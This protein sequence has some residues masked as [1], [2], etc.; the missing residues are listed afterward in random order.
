MR[1][2]VSLV[3]VLAVSSLF[4]VA[5]SAP[6]SAAMSRGVG[7]RIFAEY[8]K[9]CKDYSLV[10]HDDKKTQDKRCL[11]IRMDLK[12]GAGCD[13]GPTKVGPGSIMDCEK[14]IKKLP[15]STNN[16]GS[17]NNS[18]SGG[19]SG[20]GGNSS[21]SKKASTTEI[22]ELGR[23]DISSVKKAGVNADNN[24][25]NSVVNIAFS[26][27]GALALLFIVIGG[28]RFILSRGDP[29]S[30]AQA[31]NTIL[32]A[33]IGLVITMFAYAIVRFVVGSL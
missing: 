3:K 12:N 25:I 29:Q 26:L 1:R 21:N 16:T 13:F 17:S 27:A 7:E 10:K 15:A 6:T 33:V 8:L 11:K 14:K 31:R 23:L 30:T 24:T 2:I 28:L 22:G 4:L 32:F 9:E 18:S 5:V 20:S 19:S